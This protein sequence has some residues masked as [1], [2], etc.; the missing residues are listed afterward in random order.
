MYSTVL[1][2]YYFSIVVCYKILYYILLS[3]SF[4]LW[5]IIRY[6]IW[7]PV[8]CSRTWRLSILYIVVCVW[9]FH[10]PNPTLPR[11]PPSWQPQVFSWWVCFWF[12]KNVY[13][14]HTLDSTYKWYHITSSFSEWLTSLGLISSRSILVAAG[15]HSFF[16]SMAERRSTCVCTTSSLS[17]PLSMHV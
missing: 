14:Y 13:L 12:R 3:Y 11:P 2:I 8:L 1:Y 10:T 4:P 6:W 9:W 7:S 15:E 17:S 16:L 5:F